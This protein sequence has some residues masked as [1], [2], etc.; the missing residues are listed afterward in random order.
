MRLMPNLRNHRGSSAR[1]KKKEEAL[2]ALQE[3]SVKQSEYRRPLDTAMEEILRRGWESDALNV[4]RD[5]AKD[6]ATANPFAGTLCVERLA[7]AGKWKDVEAFV[8]ALDWTTKRRIW[9]NTGP[10]STSPT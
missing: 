1:R 2:K 5:A 7:E 10:T 3:L 4:L 6:P 9:A 8:D